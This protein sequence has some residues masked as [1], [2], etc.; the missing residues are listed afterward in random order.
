VGVRLA[1]ATA[2]AACALLLG[3]GQAPGGGLSDPRLA[4]AS[5]WAFAIGN[6]NLAGDREAV[7]NRLERF[8]V[9]VV[10]GEEASAGEIAELHE[11]D[12]AVLA[13]LSVGTIE[14]WRGWFD[15]VKRFRLKAWQDWKD[16]WFA[17]VSKARLRQ[18]LIRDIAPRMLAKGFDGLFLDNVD[19][20]EPRRHRAQRA[21]M[22]KLVRSLSGLTH[23]GGDLLFA[24][25][26]FWGLRK[27]GIREFIDGWNREDVTWT[28]DFDRRKY[29][30]NPNGQIQEALSEL[31][32]MRSLG[33]FTTA[34]N[35]TKRPSGAAVEES[36]DDA[37]SVGA[38]PYASDIGLTARRLPDPAL[39]CPD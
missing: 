39:A 32:K 24:Q 26:G 28:F 18:I 7:G 8:D 33:L 25:N 19:M 10:D 22:R 6:G 31:E 36:V 1:I 13:Y 23:D 37:C 3:A 30:R 16:E 4:D 11:R 5:S 15:R 21:G 12:T 9:V 35:Y 34:T 38:L 27:F 20:I 14:K 17:D 29:V 2:V